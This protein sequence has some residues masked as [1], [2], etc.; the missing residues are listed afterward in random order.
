MD[1]DRFGGNTSGNFRGNPAE[2]REC[3]RV[4]REMRGHALRGFVGRFRQSGEGVTPRPHPDY[5]SLSREDS[6]GD[7]GK[8]I[9]GAA[10][11]L[12]PEKWGAESGV[13][14]ASLQNPKGE[15]PASR[16]RPPP[17]GADFPE[18]RGRRSSKRPPRV[19]VDVEPATGRMRTDRPNEVTASVYGQ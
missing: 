19:H 10:V 18:S 3:D 4:R 16:A 8:N 11:D 2:Q 1:V 5:A 12:A 7:P 9:S 17:M 15:L 13:G 6:C 14:D